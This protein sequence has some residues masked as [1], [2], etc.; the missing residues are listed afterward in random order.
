MQKV[1]VWPVNNSIVTLKMSSVVEL[2]KYVYS[3][4]STKHQFLV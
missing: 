3:L 4:W 2:S 1:V